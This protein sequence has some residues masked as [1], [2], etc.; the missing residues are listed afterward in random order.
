MF[1]LCVSGSSFINIL[2]AAFEPI[3]FR[4]NI[5]EPNYYNIKTA[6]NT[7]AQTK[8]HIKMLMKLTPGFN[9]INVLR[10][11]F[12]YTILAP[13]NYKA[14]TKLQSRTFQLRNFCH[15]NIEERF[16]RKMLMTMTPGIRS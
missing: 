1:A 7:F 4:Q 8:P 3:F 6:Q 13:K 9:F 2:Q 11:H 12:S 16:A 14:E 10:A 15:Q 5:I